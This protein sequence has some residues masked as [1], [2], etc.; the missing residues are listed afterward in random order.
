MTDEEADYCYECTG[1]GDDYYIDEHGDLVCY[2]PDCPFNP[3]NEEV[4]DE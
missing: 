1:L 2:C 3:F 4:Q